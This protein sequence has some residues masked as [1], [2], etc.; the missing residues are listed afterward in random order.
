MNLRQ[1]P[2]KERL[3]E[4]NEICAEPGKCRE[5]TTVEAVEVILPSRLRGRLWLQRARGPAVWLANP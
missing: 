5:I 2:N 4:L 3:K 1:E